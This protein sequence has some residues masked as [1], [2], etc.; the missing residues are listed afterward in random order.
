M[1]K[2]EIE[3][4]KGIE[5]NRKDGSKA[6]VLLCPLHHLCLLHLVTEKPHP[7][8]VDPQ[9]EAVRVRIPI[10]YGR[11]KSGRSSADYACPLSVK[12]VVAMYVH[13]PT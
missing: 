9:S 2:E 7:A 11:K 1:H 13:E 10:E 4:I 5:E 6:S 8:I 3:G 12:W